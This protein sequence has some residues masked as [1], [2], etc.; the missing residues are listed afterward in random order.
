MTAASGP[1]LSIIS[2]TKQ[3]RD[4]LERTA[5]ALREQDLAGVEWVVVRSPGDVVPEV[6][7]VARTVIDCDNGISAALNAGTRVSRGIWLMYLNGGDAL[8]SS[9]VLA[10]IKKVLPQNNPADSVLY[11]DFLEIGKTR[12]FSKRADYRELDRNNSINHQSVVIGRALALNH[13]YDE[14]LLVGMDYDLWLRLVRRRQFVH[15]GFPIAKFYQG[16]RSGSK[17]WAIHQVIIRYVLRRVNG[18]QRMTLRDV[19]KLNYLVLRCLFRV[20]VKGPLLSWRT[21]AN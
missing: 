11:G 2:I 12:T 15:L 5:A 14:R 13:P 7:G 6:A 18:T 19:V 8:A 10:R 3:D 20:Y 1:I 9:D 16:G 17:R 4:G 21:N